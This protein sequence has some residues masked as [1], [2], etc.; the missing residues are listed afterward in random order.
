MY[1]DFEV[2]LTSENRGESNLPLVVEELCQK[3]TKNHL[4]FI[5]SDSLEFPK[6]EHFRSLAGQNDC[7]FIHIFDSF[8][9]TLVG[10]RKHIISDTDVFIDTLDEKKKVRYITER[11]QELEA[12]RHN[13]IKLGGSYLALDESKNLYQELFLFFKKRQNN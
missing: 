11:T 1:D 12:F 6:T 9:N 4:L 8:E 7:V 13:V 3:R 10:E 2:L 5:I